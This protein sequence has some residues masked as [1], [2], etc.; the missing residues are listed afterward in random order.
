M[1]GAGAATPAASIASGRKPWCG[2]HGCRRRRW[3][4]PG[5]RTR[6]RTTASVE[7]RGISPVPGP[8]SDCSVA[9]AARRA[10]AP[11]DRSGGAR[12]VVRRSTR[13]GGRLH[14]AATVG[15]RPPRNAVAGRADMP[16][17]APAP[18]RDRDLAA[19]TGGSPFDAADGVAAIAALVDAADRAAA[20]PRRGIRCARGGGSSRSSP[21]SASSGG[22][23]GVMPCTTSTPALFPGTM[24]GS[25][26]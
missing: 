9:A 3:P 14:H 7:P 18:G 21:C 22:D 13:P 10:V 8:R 2:P 24:D 17:A 4:L 26:S 11:A 5:R 1:P 12:Y 19:V 20:A 15:R 16:L 6:Q 23:V 25:N